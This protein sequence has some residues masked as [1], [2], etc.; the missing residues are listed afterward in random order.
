MKH[1]RHDFDS[2]A[3]HWDENPGRVKLA[4]DIARAIRE[5]VPITAEMNALDFGCGT[6]LVTL[7]LQ[8]F[9]R[10]ITGVDS[11]RGMLDILNRKKEEKNLVNVKT[12]LLD[13]EAGDVLEGRYHLIVSSMTLHHVEHLERL[14]AEF[15]KVACPSGYL[16]IADLD[17][18]SG[19][20]HD[21]NTGVVHS[22][23]DRAVLRKLITAAGFGG[24]RDRTA[25]TV[26][27]T[28]HDGAT[29]EFTV[30]LMTG[31]KSREAG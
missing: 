5:E 28:T 19:R 30:F 8:P 29:A 4:S 1:E 14:L 13:L 3:A 23:F 2:A 20:F 11:S 21:D 6:G 24:V 9:V 15:Y 25:A 10:S 7:A 27:K 22:G 26:R 12:M 17:Q 18:D 16:C 31:R